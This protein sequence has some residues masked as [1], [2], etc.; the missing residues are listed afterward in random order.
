M[1]VSTLLKSWATP[2]ASRPTASI[3]W[4]WRSCASLMRSASSTRRRSVRSRIQAVKRVR[5]GDSMR[6][7]ESSTGKRTSCGP[8]A[9]SSRRWPIALAKSPPGGAIIS[10]SF[11]PAAAVRGI[12]NM[13]SAAAFISTIVPSVFIVTIASNAPSSTESRST[14]RLYCGL[15][16]ALAPHQ[17]RQRLPLLVAGELVGRVDVLIAQRPGDGVVLR[18]GLEHLR[19]VVPGHAL[20][21]LQHGAERVG[22]DVGLSPHRLQH[23]AALVAG[24][25]AADDLEERLARRALDAVLLQY[26]QQKRRRLVITAH[27]CR[28]RQRGAKQ[29]RIARAIPAHRGGQDA[30]ALVIAADRRHRLEEGAPIALVERLLRQDLPQQLRQLV[31]GVDRLGMFEDSRQRLGADRPALGHRRVD[32]AQL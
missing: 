21:R 3:F 12:P 27:R 15:L 28:M 9:S 2:P 5:P 31:V 1:A 7:I 20:R 26:F 18:H 17:R 30:V 29:R 8:M 14:G 4:A 23:A 13:R 24:V 22:A 25:E 32:A 16:P 6:A 11:R 10:A 19:E